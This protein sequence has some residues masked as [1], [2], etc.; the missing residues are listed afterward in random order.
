VVVGGLLTQGVITEGMN[1]VIGM[2]IACI[3]ISFEITMLFISTGPTNDGSF[4]PV[5]VQSIHRNKAAYRVVR[6]GQSAS[7]ALHPEVPGLRKGMVLINPEVDQSCCIFFQ[8][9]VFFFNKIH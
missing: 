5:Q 2:K 3:I 4:Q 1:L 6:A 7:L 9:S 8:V